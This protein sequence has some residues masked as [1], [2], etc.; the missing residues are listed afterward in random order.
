MN[1]QIQRQRSPNYPRAAL[2]KILLRL[3]KYR[4]Q[5]TDEIGDEE[6]IARRLG[7]SGVTGAS[8]PVISALKKF[9]LLESSTDGFRFSNRAIEIITLD[10]DDP[11]FADLIELTAFTDELYA[12]IRSHFGKQYPDVNKLRE[13]LLIKGF[14]ANSIGSV[15]DLYRQTFDFVA[16]LREDYQSGPDR[17]IGIDDKVRDN[18]SEQNREEIT[19]DKKLPKSA[20]QQ[21]NFEL[22]DGI[23]LSVN[24]VGTPSI[25]ALSRLA[26]CLKTI[27]QFLES[28]DGGS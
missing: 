18:N 8:V 11:A 16:S 4:P 15:I 22:A 21:W 13:F 3:K 23:K 7:Y 17:N 2:P 26:D 20:G 24:F 1:Q 12:E 25:S 28:G 10:E 9:G 27:E 5:I 6:N 19:V 14:V